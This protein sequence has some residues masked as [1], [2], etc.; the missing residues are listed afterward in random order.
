M[1]PKGLKLAVVSKPVVGR[2]LL[3]VSVAEEMQLAGL[4]A[5]LALALV[6]DVGLKLAART[7]CLLPRHVAQ[8][9]ATSSSVA[10]LIASHKLPN[11][12]DLRPGT[13]RFTSVKHRAASGAGA[14]R[15]VNI[16]Y[17][18]ILSKSTK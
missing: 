9:P 16:R 11:D 10:Q 15:T 5:V 14:T 18:N 12:A 6:E 7:R 13:R 3:L 4:E 8:S 17:H 1:P 2:Y